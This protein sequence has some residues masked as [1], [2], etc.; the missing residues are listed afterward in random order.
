LAATAGPSSGAVNSG[1]YVPEW[2]GY[3]D[4]NAVFDSVT[5]TFAVP[6]I[7]CPATG[8]NTVYQWAGLDGWTEIGSST[9]EQSGVAEWCPP[10]DPI[11]YEAFTDMYP[12][13]SV[14][15]FTVKP[16]DT[17]TTS[18]VY[19]PSTGKFAMTVD[20][21]T[22]GQSKTVTAACAGTC[23]RSSAEVVSE[24]YQGYEPQFGSVSFSGIGVT[25]APSMTDPGWATEY[26][27]QGQPG[28]EGT[29][30]GPLDS[31]G[32]GFTNTQQQQWG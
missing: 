17:V 4:L 18:T 24:G 20:D 11:Q 19:S 14:W 8:D 30:P 25:A 22:S 5:A 29:A 2:S 6:A 15:Q 1:Y 32:D 7:T 12:A 26:L 23:A 9:V 31:A 28:D 10:G 21:V 16:G 13:S 27:I 3:I